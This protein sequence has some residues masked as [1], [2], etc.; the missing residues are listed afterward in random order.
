M[1]GW[2]YRTW[3]T[4]HWQYIICKCKIIQV[5]DLFN[6]A[7][8]PYARSVSILLLTIRNSQRMRH[9]NWICFWLATEPGFPED[10]ALQKF[11]HCIMM[12]ASNKITE[13]RLKWYGHVRR[14]KEH[15]VRRMLDVDI[16]GKRRRGRPKRRWKNACKRYMTKAGLKEDNA[17]NR[18]AWRK[19]INS[20]TPDDGTSQGWRR[21]IVLQHG[22][23]FLD[24]VMLNITIFL[25]TFSYISE[26]VYSLSASFCGHLAEEASE[27]PAKA[28]TKRIHRL[29]KV[30]KKNSYV[31]YCINLPG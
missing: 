21:C 9:A 23:C 2:K 20:Y 11:M 5:L 30:T 29:C 24:S 26:S 8:P 18:A 10:S 3:V 25:V 14:M 1:P 6:L 22:N 7:Y 15:I 19:K 17:T 28:C 13:K 27:M 4:L 31:L 12:Q 16:S